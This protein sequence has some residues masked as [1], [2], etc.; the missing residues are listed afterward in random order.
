VSKAIERDKLLVG[1]ALLESD[2]KHA[3]LRLATLA[4]IAAGRPHDHEDAARLPESERGAWEQMRCKCARCIAWD[5][6]KKALD[7]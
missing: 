7:A 6:L 3:A 4:V 2:A 1:H 5:N